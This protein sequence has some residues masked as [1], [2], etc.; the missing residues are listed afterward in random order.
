MNSESPS[1]RAA[2]HDAP[3]RVAESI[4][5][6]VTKLSAEAREADLDALAFLLDCVALEAQK[7]LASD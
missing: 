4:L 6:T 1:D 7:T 2:E 5:G 3:R